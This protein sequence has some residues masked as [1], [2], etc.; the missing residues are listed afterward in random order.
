MIKYNTL[1]EGL[2]IIGANM[3]EI[4]P[5]CNYDNIIIINSLLF[6]GDYYIGITFKKNNMWK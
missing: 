2:F 5:N 3:D 6:T 1:D 4:I